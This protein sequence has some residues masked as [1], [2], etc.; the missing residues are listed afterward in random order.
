[1]SCPC[2]RRVGI[3][4]SVSH[5]RLLSE[6]I[7]FKEGHFDCELVEH[8]GML[9]LLVDGRVDASSKV[10]RDHFLGGIIP[11]GL[12]PS[13]QTNVSFAPY[14]GDWGRF[15]CRAAFYPDGRIRVSI[16][17]PQAIATGYTSQ[18]ICVPI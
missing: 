16:I 13:R 11:E 18:A 4:N 9:V 15:Q 6:R 17:S 2:I 12:R 8:H 3:R 14:A 7:S 5:S 10:Y 1:M